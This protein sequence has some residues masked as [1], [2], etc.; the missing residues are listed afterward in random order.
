MISSCIYARGIQVLANRDFS[1]VIDDLIH[2]CH[3][4]LIS[5]EIEG[6]PIQ[7]VAS[8]KLHCWFFG[9]H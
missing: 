4:V 6:S 9:S 3:F 7:A 2:H 8:L 1:E 5:L